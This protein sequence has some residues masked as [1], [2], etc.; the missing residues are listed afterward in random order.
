[1]SCGYEPLDTLFL[2][3]LDRSEPFSPP[4]AFSVPEEID[5]TFTIVS[6]ASAALP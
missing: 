4:P 2:A 6:P 5:A 3:A 1:M